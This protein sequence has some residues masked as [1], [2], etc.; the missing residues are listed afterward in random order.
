[1][2]ESRIV[3]GFCLFRKRLKF[4][5]LKMDGL[6]YGDDSAVKAINTGWQK[7]ILLGNKNEKLLFFIFGLFLHDWAAVIRGSFTEDKN[8]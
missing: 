7:A 3:S 6:I 1:V 4:L 5:I 2:I 8:K